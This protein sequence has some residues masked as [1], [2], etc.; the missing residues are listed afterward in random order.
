MFWLQISFFNPYCYALFSNV[1][2]GVAQSECWCE[3][4]NASECTEGWWSAG[5]G[6]ASAVL[7]WGLRRG[8]CREMWR[9]CSLSC[10]GSW[11]SHADSSRVTVAEG[12]AASSRAAGQL[13]HEHLVWM[14]F[15]SQMYIMDFGSQIWICKSGWLNLNLVS[16]TGCSLNNKCKKRLGRLSA[17]CT[18]FLGKAALIICI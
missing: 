18:T 8:T 3:F 1:C 17:Q 9:C 4:G 15:G 16:K 2:C 5:Y 12:K 6:M 10:S 11:E 14:D 13:S 7:Y